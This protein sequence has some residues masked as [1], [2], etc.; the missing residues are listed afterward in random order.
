MKLRTY[1]Q[2][3]IDDC[4]DWIKKSVEPGVVE[5]TVSFGKSI[6]IAHLAKLITEMSGKKVLILC[7]NGKLVSQNKNKV[8]AIGE[9]VSVFSASLQSK[10][11]RHPITIG[12]PQSIK[13]SLSRFG[14][15]FCAILIDEGEGLTNAVIAICDQ[16][17]GLN[18]N[19]RIVGF[20]GTPYRTGTGYVYRIDVD[21][22]PVPEDMTVDPFY[23]RQIHKTDTKT[24]MAEGY[25]T[26]M[27]LG[28]INAESYDT[29]ELSTNSLG[30]FS[31]A[32]VDKAYHGQ[33]RATSAIVA[34]IVA[35]SAGKAGVMIFGATTQHCHEIME[36]LPPGLSRMVASGMSTNKKNIEDFEQQKFKYIVNIDM[37]TVGVDFPHVDVIAVL[38]K[39]EST[40]L[41]QQILGRGVRLLKNLWKD[42]PPTA[43]ERKMIIA[44]SSKPFCLYLDYTS[45]NDSIHYPDGDIWNANVKARPVKKGG[46][47]IS[48]KCPMCD[49]ENQF[50]ARPNPDE[51]GVDDAG[52]FLDLAGN[53]LQTEFGPIPA[54]FGRRCTNL[55]PIG[56]GKLDQCQYRYTSKECPHCNEPNDIA[57]KYCFSCRGE[58][59]NPNDKLRSDFKALKK[60]PSQAQ[61]DVIERLDVRESVSQAGNE[62]IRLDFKTPYRSF[63]VWL[64]KHP[65]HHDAL[66]QLELWKALDG[67]EPK[68]VRYVKEPSGFFK[69]I[70]FNVAP[71]EEPEKDL[72]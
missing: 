63:S 18:P 52:Y 55:V 48:C 29:S 4:I 67:E 59:V 30:R 28:Q 49:A 51:F 21:G 37:L 41:L 36:S 62:T 56:G 16:I 9:P 5:A 12:T 22:N 33:G 19:C 31:K 54:H 65:K 71:D 20:T 15:E 46:G 13:N 40:R 57:A 53:Q 68:S 66:H 58:I 14:K 7:P 3:C 34:D 25:L 38:R 69:I 11:T 26:P 27:V 39:T 32:D 70:A 42:D 17:K 44:Q 35:Q 24:L 8:L 50:S 10:S 60:D 43:E 1:Q 2:D 45:D 61:C 23:A 72:I 64:S 47:L 6:V